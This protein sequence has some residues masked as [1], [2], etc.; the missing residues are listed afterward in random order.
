MWPCFIFL[1]RLIGHFKNN[2]LDDIS[3][4]YLQQFSI[5]W[6]VTTIVIMGLA[7]YKVG[8]SKR[9]DA[10]AKQYAIV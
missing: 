6:Q 3:I 8:W 1:S 2:F 4:I 9:N 10:T 5:L 7:N